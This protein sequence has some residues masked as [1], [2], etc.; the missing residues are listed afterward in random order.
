[1][2]GYSYFSLIRRFST[3]ANTDGEEDI[4]PVPD[5]ALAQNYPNPFNPSTTIALSL[6]DA[7]D[8]A[9]LEIFNTRGQRVRTLLDGVPS[10][11]RLQLVWDGRDDQGS[12]LGSGIYYYRLR[13]GAFTETR[14]MLMI[15]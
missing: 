2:A 5:N 15:K 3:M 11:H 8:P 14:K 12:P 13:S 6:K 7:S 4:L 10:A 1:V 9:R